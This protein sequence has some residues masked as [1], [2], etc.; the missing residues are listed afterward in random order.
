MA[1]RLTPTME[2]ALQ[3]LRATPAGTLVSSL[4]GGRRTVNALMRRGLAEL[5]WDGAMA[6]APEHEH[7]FKSTMHMDGCHWYENH[8]ACDCGA[9]AQTLGERSPK[10]DPYSVMWMD[11]EGVEGSEKPCERCERLLQGAPARPLFICVV[12]KRQAVPA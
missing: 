5:D 9:V 7:A 2:K 4:P 6:F 10:R 3:A 12:R 1:D 11:V 8:Y